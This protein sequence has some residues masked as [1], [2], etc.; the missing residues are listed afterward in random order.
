M[1][2][3][4]S[5]ADKVRIGLSSLITIIG[6]AILALV[7]IAAV[8][9]LWD[10][11]SGDVNIGLG[12][13]FFLGIGV[14]WIG[15]ILLMS[16]FLYRARRLQYRRQSKIFIL[17][18]IGTIVSVPFLWHFFITVPINYS[19]KFF[20]ESDAL[21]QASNYVRYEFD[22]GPNW[23]EVSS[24]TSSVTSTADSVKLDLRNCIFGKAKVDYPGGAAY[25]VFSGRQYG[26]CYFYYQNVN[27]ADQALW[28][29]IVKYA[30]TLS[31][32]ADTNVTTIIPVTPEG[33]DVKAFMPNKSENSCFDTSL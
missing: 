13:L 23:S 26:T 3:I 15:L 31:V 5:T 18:L 16:S 2:H 10:I 1:G 22:V 8:T 4:F 29:G 6:I 14:I 19:Q 9:P 32:Y 11:P 12:L 24:Q 17:V 7:F 25:F 21:D 20:Q 33:V 27:T 30:C 28:D